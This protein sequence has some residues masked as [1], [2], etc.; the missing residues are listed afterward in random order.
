MKLFIDAFVVPKNLLDAVFGP[1]TD[2][3]SLT[4]DPAVP[5]QF[6]D[7][8][9]RIDI[10]DPAATQVAVADGSPADIVSVHFADLL[11]PDGGAPHRLA[12]IARAG[13]TDC[14][15]LPVDPATGQAV[16]AAGI[17]PGSYLAARSSGPVEVTLPP[18]APVMEIAAS[19]ASTAVPTE[20]PD[21]LP[22]TS[23]ADLIDGLG[24]DD[25]ISGLGSGDQLFGRQ[26]RD[27]IWGGAGDD[28]IEGGAQ[29][30]TLA[31]RQQARLDAWPAGEAAGP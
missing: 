7:A 19:A 14:I 24:G 27:D 22:G 26:G 5:V 20:G 3:G 1:G 8:D 13:S 23:G 6:Q 18:A 9:G 12:V 15:L 29:A 30:D 31:R 10:S 28:L 11:P 4:L 21:S 25:T 2:G 16:A 17:L